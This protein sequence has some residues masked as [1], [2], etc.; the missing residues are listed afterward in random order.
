[1]GEKSKYRLL[2]LATALSII[3]TG[4][5]GASLISAAETESYGGGSGTELDPYIISSAE[6]M[7]QLD[8]DTFAGNTDGKYYKLTADLTVDNISIG[9]NRGA[10]D[11]FVSGTQ[12]LPD[13]KPF[14][15]TFDGNHHKITYTYNVNY[16][17]GGLFTGLKKATVKNLTVMGKAEA[18]NVIFGSIAAIAQNSVIDNCVSEVEITRARQWT[19]GIVAIMDGTTITN[20][21]NRG[22][23]TTDIHASAIASANIQ[24]YLSN[25]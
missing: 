13:A 7:A 14:E 1:M 4:L 12:T 2:S 11:L 19:G 8:A 24:T 15:G 3:L 25:R 6:H 10:N 17:L 21:E 22:N 16:A 20:T 5:G 9:Q 18:P 23:I